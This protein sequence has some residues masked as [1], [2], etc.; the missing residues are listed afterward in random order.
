MPGTWRNTPGIANGA[1]EPLET[2]PALPEEAPEAAG[3][4]V[5]RVQHRHLAARFRQMPGDSEADHAGAD[6]DDAG[7]VLHGMHARRARAR[8][9]AQ[10]GQR[11]DHAASD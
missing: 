6:D 2:A 11:H 3:G 5:L 8:G 1:T 7:F 10:G 9:Q 4:R